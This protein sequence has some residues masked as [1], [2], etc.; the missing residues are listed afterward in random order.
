ALG[1]GGFVP[2]DSSLSLDGGLVLTQDF[3]A[4]RVDDGVGVSLR[5]SGVADDLV[6]SHV[7][8][9]PSPSSIKFAACE[10][11]VN[12]TVQISP[13]GAAGEGW[14]AAGTLQPFRAL[15]SGRGLRRM[16]TLSL[17]RPCCAGDMP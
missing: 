1:V 15:W 2:A 16:D 4:R 17:G 11:V 3:T 6:L 5:L 12:Q 14:V 8:R 13:G 7:C 10:V 9:N